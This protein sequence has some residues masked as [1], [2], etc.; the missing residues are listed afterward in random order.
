[1]PIDDVP[2]SIASEEKGAHVL[3]VGP[4]G[5]L[6]LTNEDFIN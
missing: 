3:G 5:S 4:I 6:C 2:L 1:M